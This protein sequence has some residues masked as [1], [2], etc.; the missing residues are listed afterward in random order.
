MEVELVMKVGDVASSR[1]RARA[2]ARSRARPRAAVYNY[3]L[4]P[5][6]VTAHHAARVAPQCTRE[7]LPYPDHS[8]I[9]SAAK[10]AHDE[11]VAPWMMH[12]VR[13]A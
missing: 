6:L 7:S 11:T 5:A 13:H 2:P 3:A 4:S 12:A 1:A 10:S 8:R 9:L